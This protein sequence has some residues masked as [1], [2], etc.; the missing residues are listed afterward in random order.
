MS[1]L[2]KIWTSMS[3][4]QRISLIVVPLLLCAAVF[5]LTKWRHENDFRPLYTSLA[6]EDAAAVTQ[7]IREA[8]IEYR[9]DETGSTVLVPSALI[10]E[11][12]LALAGAGLPRSGR[13]GFELFDRANL[14]ASDFTEQVNYRR[15][16]EGEL[17]RTVATLSE[18]DQARIHI[19][20]A[21]ESVFLDSRAP[22]KATVVV[23]LKRI[24]IL[25]Q[26]SVIAIANLVAS[27][28]DG[29]TPEA[30]AVIDSSGRLLNRPRPA[31]SADASSDANLDYRRQIESELIA[32]I[33]TAIEPLV[34]AGHFHAGVNVDCDFSSSEQSDEIY[35]STKSALLQSQ[36]TEESNS[37]MLSGGGTPG[38][39][40]NL[41]HPPPKEASGAT[42]LL[43]RTENASYQPGKT[44]RRTLS[45]KGTVRR[46]STAVLV[47]QTVRWE[48]SG[49]KAR[50][51]LIPASAE[52]LKGIRDVVAGITGFSD[53]RGDQITI[54]SLPFESTLS[55]EPPGSAALP[56]KAKGYDLKHPIV[57]YGGTVILLLI[58][59]IVFLGIRRPAA[60]KPGAEDMAA[61]PLE[62]GAGASALPEKASAQSQLED[63]I[64]ANEAEQ[65]QIEAE[66]IGHIKLPPNTRKSEVLVRHIRESIKGDP[67]A[68]A[69]VL[70]TWV[71]DVEGKRT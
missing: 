43:R 39:A 57:L 9:L 71:A 47:D 23:K 46:I 30:V 56:L 60:G 22:A 18:I 25:Q 20:F 62:A 45:P 68:A 64:A 15:A 63:Q 48:G 31:D 53:Q 40:A 24:G 29:L 5:G 17:E 14:G 32:K 12:R 28:V 65:A 4:S 11:A 2:T 8:G 51:T 67:V 50:K 59:A 44:V 34:G 70:R 3:A 13:I 7:K 37:S 58:L 35:D 6:P 61:S 54:E 36:T 49:A 41:P 55:S 42:G 26:P 52:V 10:A 27:S 38:T 16:L 1:Q 19:T 66:A 69:N 21:K 33:N